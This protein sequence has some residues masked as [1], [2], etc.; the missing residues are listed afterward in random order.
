MKTI[1][2][3]KRIGIDATTHLELINKDEIIRKAFDAV[4]PELKKLLQVAELTKSLHKRIIEVEPIAKLIYN[5][6]EF[7]EECR[8]LIER[9]DAALIALDK[10]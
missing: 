7:T 8:T 3:F 2:D 1:E 10:K 5:V 4:A 9:V 6:P